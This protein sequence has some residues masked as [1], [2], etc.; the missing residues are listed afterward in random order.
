[1]KPIT[2]NINILIKPEDY[3][4]KKLFENKKKQTYKINKGSGN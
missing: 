1:M 4:K 3:I 2:I